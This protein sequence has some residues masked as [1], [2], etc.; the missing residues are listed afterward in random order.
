MNFYA[1]FMEICKDE[2]TKRFLDKIIKI[3]SKANILF[4]F[5]AQKVLH[6]VVTAMS[7]SWEGLLPMFI[8]SMLQF[9][10]KLMNA[11]EQSI[12]MQ[13]SSNMAAWYQYVDIPCVMCVISSSD[14]FK[15]YFE[16]LYYTY[17]TEGFYGGSGFTSSIRNIQTV[18][19]EYERLSLLIRWIKV[20]CQ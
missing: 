5:H 15:E 16:R 11:Q 7:H 3:E 4:S 9:F 6:T 13:M 10:L 18:E 1:N 14:Y 19:E 2:W 8:V 20:P 17:V 12:P